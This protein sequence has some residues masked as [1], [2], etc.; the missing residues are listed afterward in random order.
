MKKTILLTLSPF[1]FGA[2]AVQAQNQAAPATTE[3]TATEVAAKTAEKTPVKKEAL[4]A[5]VLKAL[6]SDDYKGWEFSDASWVKENGLE[7][8]EINLKQEE[9]TTQ[10]KLNKEGQKMN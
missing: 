2:I 5:P 9:K 4:P 1:L 10:V 3:T 6:A 8:Y 7:Y